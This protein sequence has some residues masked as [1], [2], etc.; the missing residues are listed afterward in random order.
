MTLKRTHMWRSY[1]SAA[2]VLCFELKC[3]ISLRHLHSLS[4]IYKVARKLDVCMLS[5]QQQ[6]QLE[7]SYMAKNEMDGWVPCLVFV[8]GHDVVHSS[9]GQVAGH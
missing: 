2:G 6:V 7:E 3:I 1:C 5:C 4:A 8:L 9:Q